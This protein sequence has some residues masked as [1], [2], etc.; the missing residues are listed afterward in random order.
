MKNLRSIYDY[1]LDQ[2]KAFPDKPAVIVENRVYTYSDL[3]I[4]LHLLEK[5]LLLK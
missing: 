3:Y 1:F 2:V 4:L 5:E